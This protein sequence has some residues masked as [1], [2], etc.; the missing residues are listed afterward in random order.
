MIWSHKQ[1]AVIREIVSAASVVVTWK[2]IAERVSR[3]LGYFVTED[4]V[5]NRANR[6]GAERFIPQPE[7]A[8]VREVSEQYER[9]I[10][11][12]E[13]REATA[14]ARTEA[15]SE[16]L[17]RVIED[18]VPKIVVPTFPRL[19]AP[20]RGTVQEGL[21]IIS[22]AHYGQLV[23]PAVVGSGW[24][25]SKYLFEER[26]YALRSRLSRIIEIQKHVE[27]FG[28]FHVFFLGDMVDGVDMRRGQSHRNDI[29]SAAMQAFGV[30]EYF[31]RFLAELSGIVPELYV[32]C[33]YG[34][35]GRVG[36]FGVNLGMDNWDFVAYQA[37]QAELRGAENI[38]F[39]IP[40]EKY[41]IE[42]VL[43][44]NIYYA[45][46][47]AIGGKGTTSKAIKGYV[48][49]LQ[50]LHHQVFDLALFGHFH[51]PEQYA[52]GNTLIYMNGA[53]PGGDDYS[54]NQ[55]GL[56]TPPRQWAFGLSPSRAFP[57]WEYQLDLAPAH[58]ATPPS[59]ERVAW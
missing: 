38:H 34:N 52:T 29:N 47:D 55:L 59:S 40:T 8:V 1:D 15:R 31:S 56:A 35:H 32:H 12:D 17:L 26:F 23:D 2:E 10:A 4:Q 30:A 58:E 44:H 14:K 16:R 51:T 6:I 42:D 43:G 48:A 54:I 3:R 21:A 36:D 25:Y 37:M 49:S 13:K 57:T 9:F 45:H 41:G 53:W 28:A 7:P 33:V 22:D 27:P 20:E 24:D 11:A 19:E 46:G 50:N 18:T 5:R 39:V